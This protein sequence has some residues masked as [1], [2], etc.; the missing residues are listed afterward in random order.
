MRLGQ[1]QVG[2]SKARCAQGLARNQGE[3]RRCRVIPGA[4]AEERGW[5]RARLRRPLEAVLLPPPP[6]GSP[7]EDHR[8][9]CWLSRSAGP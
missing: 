9:R 1:V 7:S 5:V 6:A 2:P 3:R 4:E 8:A